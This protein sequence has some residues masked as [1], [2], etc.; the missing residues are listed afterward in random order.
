MNSLLKKDQ[1]FKWTD[2][3]QLAFDELKDRLQ[4]P[5]ILALPNDSDLM[6]LDTD[7]SDCSIGAVLSQ[8]Q[9]G[10]ERVISYA[11]RALADGEKNY[12]V[13]RKE[14]LAIVYFLKY[15]NCLLYTSP[16]P[17]DS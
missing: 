13:T 14:L 1:G 11:G 7:A 16:S 8:M 2:E 4:K 5:P 12:C 15:Y 17:R 10:E 6:I 3:C 9:D